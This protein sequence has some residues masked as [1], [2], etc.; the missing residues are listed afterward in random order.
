MLQKASMD[1]NRPLADIAE[2][3]LTSP[4]RFVDEHAQPSARRRTQR[5]APDT[6][7]DDGTT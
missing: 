5:S 4:E 1:G 3:A 7:H 2:D 6:P